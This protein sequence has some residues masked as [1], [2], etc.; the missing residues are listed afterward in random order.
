MRGEVVKG[1]SPSED[2]ERLNSRKAVVAMLT[3]AAVVL[4]AVGVFLWV[5][6]SRACQGH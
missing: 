6:L 3:M 4:F 1:S 5:V 2:Q